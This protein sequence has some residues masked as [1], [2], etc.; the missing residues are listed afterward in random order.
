M[1]PILQTP[2]L[3]HITT[4]FVNAAVFEPSIVATEPTDGQECGVSGVRKHT[5]VFMDGHYLH[6]FVQATLDVLPAGDLRGSTLV[7]S[8]DGR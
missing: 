5:K 2:M 7:V 4:T 6:N 1:L 8:G 3:P